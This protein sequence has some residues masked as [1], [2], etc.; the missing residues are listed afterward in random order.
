[1]FKENSRAAGNKSSFVQLVGFP[2]C[3]HVGEGLQLMLSLAATGQVM[4]DSYYG[5]TVFRNAE[6]RTADRKPQEISC[7]IAYFL[8]SKTWQHDVSTDNIT[9]VK[10]FC[11]HSAQLHAAGAVLN[12]QRRLAWRYC[13]LVWSFSALKAI[14]IAVIT[15]CPKFVLQWLKNVRNSDNNNE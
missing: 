8:G 11:C 9:A 12:G 6:N 15:C 10:T 14:T 4:H 5:A 3:K 2:Q 13:Q 1:M 7:H